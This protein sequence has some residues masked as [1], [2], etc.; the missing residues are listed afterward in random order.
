MAVHRD[1]AVNARFNAAA[2]TQLTVAEARI[3]LGLSVR[4]F[5]ER[6]GVSA[7]LVRH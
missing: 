2:T 3:E 5:V 6:L 7:G 1:T 4:G